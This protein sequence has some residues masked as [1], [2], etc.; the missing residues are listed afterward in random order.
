M[1][2]IK[3]NIDIELNEIIKY[4]NSLLGKYKFFDNIYF[5]ELENKNF[6]K[7]DFIETQIQFYN[8]ANFFP[9]FLAELLKKL[10]ES[11]LKL[12]I[13]ENMYEDD[14]AWA[15]QNY[16]KNT[17]LTFLNNLGISIKD[18][19]KRTLWPEVRE[20]IM[21]IWGTCALDTNTV[22]CAT[23]GTLEYMFLYISNILE[24]NIINLKWLNK[25]QVGYY[26]NH[27]NLN[28]KHFQDFFYLILNNWISSKEDKYYIEQ[29]ISLSV[30]S[31]NLLFT[32]LYNNKSRK[33]FR[34]TNTSQIKLT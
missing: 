10:P 18:I 15:D 19:E 29:G 33:L 32:E 24:K 22:S 16:P 25:E 1:K 3:I 21:T 5:L 34:D 30:Y 31:F 27:E 26:I 4:V 13:I 20:F 11:S 6:S 9:V 14:C 2:N 8:V 17:F 12:N 7:E 28:Q 23:L